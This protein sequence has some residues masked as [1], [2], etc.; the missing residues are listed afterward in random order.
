[1]VDF[2]IITYKFIIPNRGKRNQVLMLEGISNVSYGLIVGDSVAVG[3]WVA[4]GVIGVI[5][6]VGAWVF[7]TVGVGV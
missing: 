4:A 7:P 3:A 1:M 6:S 2:Q 5:V